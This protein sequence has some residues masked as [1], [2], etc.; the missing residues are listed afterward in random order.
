MARRRG[1]E[2][3]ST[4]AGRS[5]GV[6]PCAPAAGGTPWK[7]R[8]R[9]YHSTPQS[10]PTRSLPSRAKNQEEEDD[11][12]TLKK[13]AG[14]KKTGRG[15]NAGGAQRPKALRRQS[16]RNT[17]RDPEHPIVIDDEVNEEYKVRDDQLAIVPLRRSP[18]LH[19]EDKGS[20]KSLLPSNWQETSHNRKA[21]N[22]LVKYRSQENLKR[23]RKNAGLKTL[24]KLKSHNKPQPLCQDPQDIPTRKKVTDVTHIKSEK[25]ELKPN[26]S[27]VLTRKRKRGTEGRLSAKRR[28][29]QESKSL[30][31]Y[32]QENVPSKEPKKAIHKKTGKDPSIVVKHKVGHERSTIDENINEPSGTKREGMKN[33]CGEDDWTEEQDMALRKAYFAA[34]PS[35]HFWKRVSKLV[36]GRSAEDCFNRIHAD[37][38][39]PTPI[40]PRPRTSKTTFSPIGSFALSDPKLPNLLESTVG[41][42]RT[43]KQKSLAAQKTVRHLL[44]KH[45]LIDQAQEADHFS[46]FETSPS[47]FPL[48][49]SFEDSPGTPESYLNSGSLGKFSRSSSARKKTFSRLRAERA[50]PSPAVLKPIKNLILHE[51]YVNQLSRREGTKRP[52]KRTPGSK[53]AHS[54]KAL[55]RQQVGGL[56]AAKNALI[57]EATDFISQFKKLQAN[58]LAHIVENSEDDDIDGDASDSCHDDDKE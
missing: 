50:E 12:Q 6:E 11:V 33:F 22:A 26:H 5:A 43:A 27:E 52:R 30:P 3:D 56:K 13:Q 4:T 51:K 46:L 25:Q 54:G 57:S 18:R 55:S 40:A 23:N 9:S 41:R 39:T 31:A 35:P 24:T 34:R 10:L 49:I 17:G 21:Q 1:G 42:Q 48:N 28:S 37:L 19:Q 32:C 53:A 8:L 14:P 2:P 38:S 47:A 16:P 45:S 36:P 44:Q 58:S 20:G 7:G 29:Y 15:R